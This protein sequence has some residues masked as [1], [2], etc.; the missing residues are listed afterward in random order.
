MGKG[1]EGAFEVVAALK[2]VICME[3]LRKTKKTSS[4]AVSLA[5]VQA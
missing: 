3:S 2:A 5:E 1:F 4:H